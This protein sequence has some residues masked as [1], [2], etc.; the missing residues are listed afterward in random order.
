M[1]ALYAALDQLIERYGS[2][3]WQDEAV[4][5]RAEYAERTGRVFE[6]DELYEER[7]TAFLEWY[8]VERPLPDEGLAPAALAYR[9]TGDPACRAWALSHRS[10]F[11]V[12]DLAPG[13]V[14]LLDLVAGGL[15]EVEEPRKLAGVAPGDIAEARVVGWEGAPRFG[16]TFLYHPAGAREALIAHARRLRAAGASR[17]DVVN[18]AATL[19]VRALR[20]RHVA[21]ERV[22]EMGTSDLP[23]QAR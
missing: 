6:D 5:A 17:T 4:R 18:F 13:R 23:P 7:T 11:S 12:E 3:A 1:H 19:R 20:Y 2:G 10:L 14:L 22:Y 21:A 9:E 16:R 8:V 15:F